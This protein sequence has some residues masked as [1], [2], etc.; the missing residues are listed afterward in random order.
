[1]FVTPWAAWVKSYL[2]KNMCRQFSEAKP[3]RVMKEGDTCRA[4][5]SRAYREGVMLT[6]SCG[7]KVVQL[8]FGPVDC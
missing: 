2:V 8:L 5:D 3:I 1:M 7:F 4:A 6:W